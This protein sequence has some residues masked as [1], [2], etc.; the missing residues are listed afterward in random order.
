MAEP[1]SARERTA[2]LPT[3]LQLR[4]GR[5]RLRRACALDVPAVVALLAEDQIASRREDA[6]DPRA[7]ED[8][9]EA[10]AAIDADPAHDLVVATIDGDVAGT[11]QVSYLP[12]L[13]RRGALRAQV[14]AVR[15]ARA[16]RSDGLGTAM[17]AWVAGEARRR[18][19]ALVQLTTDDTRT[20]AHRFYERL[21][22][23]A[24][25]RGFKLFL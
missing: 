25:H 5:A 15:V 12:G 6:R 10:F 24:S 3:D 22:F 9:L 19:C 4:A 23:T 14:E 13:A 2:A 7:L 17:M 20:D 1:P 21:G 11:L 18:G 8:Y 16:H